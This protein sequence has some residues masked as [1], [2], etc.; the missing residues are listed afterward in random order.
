MTSSPQIRCAP[1]GMDPRSTL[2]ASDVEQGIAADV[3]E[4]LA[5]GHNGEKATS[6]RCQRTFISGWPTRE[7]T[8]YS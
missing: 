2:N 7:L 4:L 6:S 1:G 3:K 8:R 5:F